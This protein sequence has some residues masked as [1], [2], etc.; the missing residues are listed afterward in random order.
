[1]KWLG[2]LR[3]IVGLRKAI[4]GLEQTLIAKTLID[5]PQ[6]MTLCNVQGLYRAK[7][8]HSPLLRG[9]VQYQELRGMDRQP[10]DVIVQGGK[11]YA[12]EEN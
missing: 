1:M 11:Y 2:L 3:G 9:L 6:A 7:D 5:N 8:I 4:V 10:E 12:S